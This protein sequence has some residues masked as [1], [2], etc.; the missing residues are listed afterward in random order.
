MTIMYVLYGVKALRNQSVLH[1]T[2]CEATFLA[3]VLVRGQE[4]EGVKVWG[5]GKRAYETLLSLVLN[6]EYGDITDPSGRDLVIR[7]KTNGNILSR[8]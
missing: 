2:R 1:V 5:F 7:L 4:E 3:P 8:N 6:P